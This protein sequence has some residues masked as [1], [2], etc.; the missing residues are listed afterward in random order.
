VTEVRETWVKCK[1]LDDID[2]DGNNMYHVHMPGCSAI[3]ALTHE[4]K[5]VSWSSDAH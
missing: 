5:E 1:A 2:I 4:D 3:P